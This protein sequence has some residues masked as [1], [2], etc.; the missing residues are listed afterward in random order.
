MTGQVT[1]EHGNK[2]TEK[3][4][5]QFTEAEYERLFDVIKSEF[6]DVDIVSVDLTGN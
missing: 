6:G 1:D 4:F 5:G 3:H 2:V